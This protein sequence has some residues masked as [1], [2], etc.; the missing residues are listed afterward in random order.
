VHGS[1][2]QVPVRC[3]GRLLTAPARRLSRGRLLVARMRAGSV[4]RGPAA[5]RVQSRGAGPQIQGH[6]L[7]R[8]PV[9]WRRS[10]EPGGARVAASVC[11]PARRSAAP[12]VLRS[13]LACSS[14]EPFGV[15][16]QARIG[17]AARG[18]PLLFA[19]RLNRLDYF[20]FRVR[21]RVRRP[22]LSSEAGP[23]ASGVPSAPAV[24]DFLRL[25]AS[26]LR[27]CH[28]AWQNRRFWT[29]SRGS[30]P[31]SARDANLLGKIVVSG[32]FPAAR[33]PRAPA[34][35][36]CYPKSL[37]LGDFL[38]LAA[39]EPQGCQFAR[40]HRRFCAISRGSPPPGSRDAN[41][42]GKIAVSGRFPVTRRLRAPEMPIF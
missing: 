9:Q 10:C 26:E 39:S 5:A 20:R 3:P 37:Y 38:R 23:I 27:S 18:W 42:L 17:R 25:P 40:Q 31:P 32:R 34:M 14:L 1:A 4:A 12:A 15:F 29:I 11:R 24:W 36:I 16:V 13:S 21:A 22:A 30:P 8:G 41:L 7:F 6:S 19:A 28:F 35:P 2:V 33:C